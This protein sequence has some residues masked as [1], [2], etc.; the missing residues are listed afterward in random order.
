MARQ[1]E[2]L[3][4][5]NIALMNRI[6]ELTFER[7]DLKRR[8]DGS[9]SALHLI[10]GVT[11]TEAKLLL[12]LRSGRR[13]TATQISH[14]VFGDESVLNNIYVHLSHLKRHAWFKRFSGRRST[15][16]QLAPETCAHI[17]AA[18]ALDEEQKRQQDRQRKANSVCP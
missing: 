2:D 15:G 18:L 13:C 14:D 8:I 7:D 6:E 9:T 16:I 4:R 1:D 3:L 12:Y 10:L 5:Q 17:E 11:F